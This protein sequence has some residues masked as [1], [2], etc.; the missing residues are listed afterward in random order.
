MK[1]TL[2]EKVAILL[3]RIQNED[4][5]INSF[6][7]INENALGRAREIDKRIASK[8]SGKLAG[9][10]ISVKDSIAVAGM[11]C[12]AGS[13]ML[14]NYVAPYD[15]TAVERIKAGDGLIIGKTNM[16]QF[17]CG[18][19]GE[20]SYFGATKN[21]LNNDL[22]PGGSSSGAAAS[23][24]AGF[25]DMAI[26]GDTGGSIRCPASFCGLV[27]I[28]PTYGLVSRFG[29]IDM[30]MSLEQIGVIAKN[31]RDA[32]LLLSVI[33]GQDSRDNATK[34]A[35]KDYTKF[36]GKPVRGLKIGVS[37]EL[38]SGCD[39]EV[40]SCV[41][42]A[43]DKLV[44]LGA[45]KVPI[46]LESV[47]F[48]VSAYYLNVYAE[49]ASAMQKYDGFKYG[50]RADDDNLVDCVSM[51]RSMAL[52]LENKRRIILGTYITMKE[53]REKWYSIAL[54]A[55]EMIRKDFLGALKKCDVIISPTMPFPP[56]RLGEKI[57][58]PVAM[59]ASDVLTVSANLSGVP[60]A[61]V[62]S[63]KN[64]MI[65]VQVMAKPFEEEKIFRVMSA[66]EKSG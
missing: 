20:T 16:D 42:N 12:T 60:A 2:E 23:V 31:V 66:Y 57:E 50:F 38:F 48:A 30:A 35:G 64:K 14:E 19:S 6:I 54:R 59:Y 7:T 36:C 43:I 17:S 62:P 55:R 44:A 21:P 10:A 45:K 33:A 52:S 1:P 46:K 65:G 37:E 32:A 53:F 15:A 47:K 24:A 51:S 22:V 9:Y 11:R 5:A 63:K 25:C 56:F 39:K 29:L 8:K 58:D 18:S 27:G 28:K 26:G 34:N 4:K 3:N 61:T 49:F 13:K 40:E 41:K